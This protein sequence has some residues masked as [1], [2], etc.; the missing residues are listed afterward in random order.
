MSAKTILYVEDNEMNAG[1][2]ARDLLKRTSYRLL[3]AP[4]GIE[5]KN[6]DPRPTSLSTQI[7]PPCISTNFW[8]C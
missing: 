4:D 7:R 3:E 6:V 2:S 1:S 8:R 5:K